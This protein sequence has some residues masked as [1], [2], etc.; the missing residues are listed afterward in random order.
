MEEE[1]VFY[2]LIRQFRTLLALHPNASNKLENQIEELKRAQ[3]WQKEKL[4]KQSHLFTLP[5]LIRLYTHL[6]EL[7]KGQ[8]TGNLTLPLRSSI[9]IFLLEI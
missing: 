8:K 5:Q 6:F 2:M 7:D 3:P 4:M 1:A 9:D